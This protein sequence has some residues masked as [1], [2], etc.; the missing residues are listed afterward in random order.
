MRLSVFAADTAACCCV[1]LT[2]PV[3][4]SLLTG[5]SNASS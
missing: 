1:L 3:R 2:L 5:S 4:S